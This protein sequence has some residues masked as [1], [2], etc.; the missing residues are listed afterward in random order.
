MR[1][2]QDLNDSKTSV[3]HRI[4]GEIIANFDIE[5]K[6]E[7]PIRNVSIERIPGEIQP[8]EEDHSEQPQQHSLAKR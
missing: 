1:S 6:F 8:R 3:F 5:E 7:V 4:S 2:N